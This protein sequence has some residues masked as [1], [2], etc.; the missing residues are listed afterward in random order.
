MFDR[1]INPGL[2]TSNLRWTSAELEKMNHRW[3]TNS[4]FLINILIE[5]HIYIYIIIHRN[6][7][8]SSLMLWLFDSC[9]K[10]CA[11]TFLVAL[12]IAFLSHQFHGK[13]GC[14][15]VFTMGNTPWIGNPSGICFIFFFGGG[16][17]LLQVLVWSQVS[18]QAVAILRPVAMPTTSTGVTFGPFG[19][20]LPHLLKGHGNTYTIHISTYPLVI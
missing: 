3:I 18:C 15:K 14:F 13:R 6:I 10:D 17:K 1:Q 11:S 19:N 5:P 16:L 7:S 12:A 9:T 2:K 20:H 8:I 4:M